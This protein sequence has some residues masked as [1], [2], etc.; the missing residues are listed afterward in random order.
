MSQEN[1][2]VIDSAAAAPHSGPSHLLGHHPFGTGFGSTVG[3]ALASVALGAAGAGSVAIY[4][5]AATGVVIGGWAG[6]AIS[7]RRSKRVDA[8]VSATSKS[9]DSS[10]SSDADVATP[11]RRLKN[12]ATPQRRLRGPSPRV[13]LRTIEGEDHEARTRHAAHAA[14]PRRSANFGDDACA[15]DSPPFAYADWRISA[16][17]DRNLVLGGLSL[18][19]MPRP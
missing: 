1:A 3:A 18:T 12:A 11:Q 13:R 17:R 10:A 4:T 15:V 5:S 6:H 9:H 16:D 14:L 19:D 8:D 2:L 7:R